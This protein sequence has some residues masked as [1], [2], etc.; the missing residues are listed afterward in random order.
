MFTAL[1]AY[2]TSL[3]AILPLPAFAFVASFIEEL[4]AP[5]PSPFVLLITGAAAK[6]QLLSL[7]EMMVL[8]LIATAGKTI[9]A[10]CV[11]AIARYMG[12]AI[13][14]R[15][16]NLLG[17]TRADVAALGARFRGTARDY[18]LFSTLRALPIVPS[19]LLSVGGG[20]LK[21]PLRLFITATILGT[22]VR[23]A[24]YFYAG[25][26]GTQAFARIIDT[27]SRLED[28]VMLGALFLCALVVWRLRRAKSLSSK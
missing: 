10:V 21:L 13:F 8:I 6:V 1:E 28:Y 9:G 24:L 22:I 16:P 11:Y 26:V 20:I 27:S 4:V 25:Y 19:V 23:D 7:G 5:I 2:I 17:I 18:V 15:F 3:A 14:E 12:D